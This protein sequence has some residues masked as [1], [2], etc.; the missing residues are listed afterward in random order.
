MYSW[1]Y[2]KVILGGVACNTPTLRRNDSGTSVTNFTL[3]TVESWR[4][5][6]S[7]KIKNYSK[8]HKIV[9]WG[10][11][12]ERAVKVVRKDYIYVVEGKLNYHRSGQGD[13]RRNVAE[14]KAY[15]ID[16]KG[17]LPQPRP[18][19]EEDSRPKPQVLAEATG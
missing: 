7:G 5:K 2:N 9:C 18:V 4:D 19:K 11:T 16:K 14:V 6:E 13:D 1:S 10:K 15:V 3:K 12:A 17:K 8:Y